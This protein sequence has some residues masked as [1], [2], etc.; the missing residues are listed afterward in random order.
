MHSCI[1]LGKEFIAFIR[2]RG[3]SGKDPGIQL[4]ESFVLP[5]LA[6]L[7]PRK[8]NFF[9]GTHSLFLLRLGLPAKA[10]VTPSNH[11]L[12]FVPTSLRVQP[13]G[14][15]HRPCAASRLPALLTQELGVT[16]GS[17][18]VP[19]VRHVFSS[20]RMQSYLSFQLPTHITY[21]CLTDYRSYFPWALSG[22][23]V[24]CNSH[25]AVQVGWAPRT[26]APLHAPPPWPYKTGFFL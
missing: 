2:P 6:A 4:H 16:P 12:P 19:L 24:P 3:S 5:Q 25:P 15:G 8:K 26:Q 17:P 9:Q 1:F 22:N 10:L 23:R 20:Q 14:C 21:L 7:A 13:P 18:G 11:Q